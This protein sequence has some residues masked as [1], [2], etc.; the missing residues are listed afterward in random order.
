M[1]PDNLPEMLVTLAILALE[2][3]L[4]GLCAYQSRKPVNPLK[5][6]LLPY[7]G[8]TIFLGL[9]IFVTMAHTIS[10]YSGHR[11]EAKLKNKGQGQ[12]PGR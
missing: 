1:D 7:A 4:L 11:L 12:G 3:A 6:R 9:A 8:L 2:F 10:V 5:P